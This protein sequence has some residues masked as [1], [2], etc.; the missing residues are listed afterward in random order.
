M[1]SDRAHG[2]RWWFARIACYL[3]A[4]VLADLVTF[5]IRSPQ[6]DMSD[7]FIRWLWVALPLKV[8]LLVSLVPRRRSERS[9]RLALVECAVIGAVAT[10]FIIFWAK[11]DLSRAFMVL[12]LVFSV[13][14]LLAVNAIMGTV[15][16]DG[17]PPRAERAR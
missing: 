9:E 7:D 1:R 17:E 2:V 12:Q 15:H 11:V 8:V 6:T 5:A 14:A 10:T 13:V 4:W 3:A 16:V